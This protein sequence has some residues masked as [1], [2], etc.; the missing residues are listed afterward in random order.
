MFKKV[1]MVTLGTILERALIKRKAHELGITS[2]ELAIKLILIIANV[3][4][5]TLERKVKNTFHSPF[6]Y[7]NPTFCLRRLQITF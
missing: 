2:N 4:P 5:K 6:F 7:S 1:L 3:E